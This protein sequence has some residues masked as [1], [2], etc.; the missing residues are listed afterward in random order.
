MRAIEVSQGADGSSNIAR[1]DIYKNPFN[2]SLGVAL[3][4]GSNLSYTVQHTFYTPTDVTDDWSTADWYDHEFMFGQTTESD[5]N[6]AFPVSGI[7]ITVA[8]WS[9]G[10]ATL[11][12]TQAG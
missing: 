10:T 7:R 11:T 5:G 6:Y 3:A 12:I 8:S 2:A 9:A 4:Q 1:M